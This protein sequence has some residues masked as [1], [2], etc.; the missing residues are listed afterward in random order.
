MVKRI[1][2]GFFLFL[3]L[4]WIFAPKHELYYM[5]EKKLKEND[6]IISNE[7]ITDTWFGLNIKNAQIYAKGVKLAEAAELQLN[8]FFLYNT[9]SV[10]SIAV[11]ES[12]HNMA[13]KNIDE[14]KATYTVIDPIHVNLNAL[15]SFGTMDGAI[16]LTEKNIKLLFPVVKELNGIKKYLNKN[17]EGGWYYETNY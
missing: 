16:T 4:F 8:I 7:T 2:G 5:L 6:I 10:N 14:I 15:G 12:L 1:I 13:P 11:D 3:L 9:L 17:K